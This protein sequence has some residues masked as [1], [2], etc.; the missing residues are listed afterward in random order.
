M[1]VDAICTNALV[2]KRVVTE[3][4][5]RNLESRDHV[6]SDHDSLSEKAFRLIRRPH[7]SESPITAHETASSAR[8]S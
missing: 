7:S 2:G 3:V 6:R 5:S 1:L 8:L 4:L